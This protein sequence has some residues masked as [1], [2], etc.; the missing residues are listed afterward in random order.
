MLIRDAKLEDLSA[1]TAIYAHACKTS[2]ATWDYD[3]P[4][5]EL[6]QERF[7]QRAKAGYP[8]LV[9]D[10]G[11]GEIAGFAYASSFHPHAGFRFS[12]EN[13]I[14]VAEGWQRRGIGRKLLDELVAAC[15]ARGFRQMIAGVS[16]PGGEASLRFHEA[17]GFRKVGDFQN[18]GWKHGQWL[19]A[20]YLMR[21]LGEGDSTP[22]E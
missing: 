21:A 11:D 19:T 2:T 9:A 4:S 13:S 18:V 7:A 17:A 14:Y 10:A 15:E 16:M 22:P 1:T 5:L 8:F 3:P 20:V 6:M 12:V